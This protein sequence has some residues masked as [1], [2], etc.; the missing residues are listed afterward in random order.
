MSKTRK[1]DVDALI[2]QMKTQYSEIEG[3]YALSLEEKEIKPDLKVKVKGFLEN[4]RSVLDYAAH[5]IADARGITASKVYFP[6][7]EKHK[8]KESFD[9]AI[10]RNLPG[11]EKADKQ[12]F[13]YLESVQSYHNG[14][15]W[16]ADLA[17]T[18]IDNK[19]S[20]L[21]PQIRVE[22]PSLS[23]QSNGAGIR[24]SGGA[25]ISIGHGASISVGGRRIFGGQVISAN[26]GQVLGDPG[27]E[28][29]KEIWVDFQ[30]DGGISA[31]RL[32]KQV[33]EKVPQVV[34]HIYKL[35]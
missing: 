12:I 20:R 10:G 34:E 21:T 30:F 28:V 8:D 11:L 1:D 15:E 6:I 13:S 14:N 7:I 16:L 3:L 9:G 19:H 17:T 5:D 2:A 33:S 25:S 32:L 24:M 4:A 29:K 27:L 22:T 26:S 31:I 18:T 23:I 35:I